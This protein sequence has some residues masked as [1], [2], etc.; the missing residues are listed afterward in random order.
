LNFILLKYVGK[1]I[2]LCSALPTLL[3]LRNAFVCV[4]TFA[5]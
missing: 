1:F 4:S 3:Q 5:L 2:G